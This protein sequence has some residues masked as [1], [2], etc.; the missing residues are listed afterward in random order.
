[1][2]R[3]EIM[4]HGQ[5]LIRMKRC[6]RLAWLHYHSRGDN[7]LPFYH[8]K[9]P[10]SALWSRAYDLDDTPQGH[11][12][13]TMEDTMRILGSLQPGE[14]ARFVRMSWHG[15][16]VTIPWLQKLD[17][18]W[19][20]IWP[21][22]TARE[23]EAW[24]MDI[25]RLIAQK[26]GIDIREQEAVSISRQ[27]VRGQKLDLSALFVKSD[28]LENRKHHPSRTIASL[29][30]TMHPD[31]DQL[32]NEARTLFEGPCPPAV[33]SRSCALGKRCTYYDDCFQTDRRSGDDTLFLR[34]VPYRFE[35]REGPISQLDPA[36]LQE[37]PVAWAQY[38][39]SLSSPW[40]SRPDLGEW[41]AD[42][43]PPFSYLDFEWDTFAVPPYEGM[44]SFD[45]LCFQFSLHTET[46]SGLEH[47]SYFGWGDCRKEFLDRLLASV[48]AEGTIF[49]YN[50]EGA[51]RLRLKQ[52]AVQFPAYALKLQKIWERMKDLAKPFE[53]GLYYDLRMKS[54]F[55]LKQIVQM[56]TDDP[57]YNRLAIHDGLQ[58]VRA[59]R[60]YE[61]ADEQTRKRI[62]E[63]LDRYCQM[64]TYA[65]YL[66]LH[67]LIQAAK[68]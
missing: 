11:R 57:V 53:T 44:K 35:I 24:L 67:G 29:Q 15:L 37:Y 20:A 12:G 51:E 48:P 18:G 16:R 28:C 62:R 34:S 52:L 63:E 10:F 27:Y 39:A 25:A 13:D 64:D 32:V 43:K 14:S 61:T 23:T 8:M 2:N 47:T 40:I 68:E 54:R 65:E 55:S 31:L 1:M 36:G 45:V 30:E 21:M 26:A 19:K 7:S 6:P 5:D 58:A 50:M 38:Q 4:L 59:Y 33:N 46:D 60:C 66:V 3:P 42:A 17:T 56:F 41:L 9:E 22:M 49:V